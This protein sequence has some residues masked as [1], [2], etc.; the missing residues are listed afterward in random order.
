M[1]GIPSG[2][3]P[4]NTGGRFRLVG[5]GC[6]LVPCLELGFELKKLGKAKRI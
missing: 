4:K 2:R 5:L 3:T 6:V 1:A